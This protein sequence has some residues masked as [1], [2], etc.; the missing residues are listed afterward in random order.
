MMTQ[1]APTHLFLFDI[2][3]TLISS[4]GAGEHALRLTVEELFNDKNGLDRIEIAGRTDQ[5]ITH[6]LF[7]KYGVEATPEAITG[8]LDR[9]LTHLA[10]Q[11]PQ[12]QGRVL[13][14]IL[15]LLDALKARPHVALALLTGNLERGAQLKLT[16]YG[17]WEYFDFGAYA[18]DHGDRN[19]LGPVAQ[20]RARAHHGVEFPPERIYVLGDTPH[21]ITCGRA[22]GAKTVG[23]ATGIYPMEALASYRP[24][25]VY[26]DLSDVERVLREIGV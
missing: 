18:D 22:I 13:P 19:Q 9:Y 1:A 20:T 17:L 15:P 5:S 26:Q 11:L 10:E 7:A 24:D 16:H 2:D 21:D 4:G 12:K 23:I 3:G 14:G 8:L 6:A 25:F